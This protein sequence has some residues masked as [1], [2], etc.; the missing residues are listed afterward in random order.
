MAIVKTI[1]DGNTKIH[2]LND[3]YA[4]KTPEEIEKQRQKLQDKINQ[5]AYRIAMGE[6]DIDKE[7]IS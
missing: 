6:F 7:H 1:I 2:I 3:A 4:N 5:L